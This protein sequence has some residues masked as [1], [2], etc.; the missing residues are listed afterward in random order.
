MN[1][2]TNTDPDLATFREDLEALKRNVA[3][4]I[5]HIRGGATNR[6]QNTDQI[7]RAGK[8]RHFLRRVVKNRPLCI[9]APR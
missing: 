9:G 6:V 4:P 1:A 3:S 7:D 2:S 8:E 5:E